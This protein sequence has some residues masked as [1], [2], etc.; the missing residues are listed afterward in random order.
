MSSSNM[1]EF[2]RKLSSAP[3]SLPPRVPPPPHHL[4]ASSQVWTVMKGFWYDIVTDTHQYLTSIATQPNANTQAAIRAGYVVYTA[5]AATGELGPSP[6]WCLILAILGA[7]GGGAFSSCVCVDKES[8]NYYCFVIRSYH[9]TPASHHQDLNRAGLTSVGGSSWASAF[10]TPQPAPQLSLRPTS[11]L[12]ALRAGTPTYT[13]SSQLPSAKSS[14][15][16]GMILSC[17]AHS[18][19]SGHVY[20]A[21]TPVLRTAPPARPSP[22]RHTQNGGACCDFV[23]LST[24]STLGWRLS[25]SW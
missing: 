7:G 11:D 3:T 24:L 22:Q 19:S 15:G 6:P 14:P 21:A 10:I 23:M 12:N 18:V 5:V 1:V 25:L 20:T 13:M 2:E 9:Q 8:W 16:T 17:S 4:P